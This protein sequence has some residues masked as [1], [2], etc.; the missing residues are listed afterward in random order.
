MS[1]ESLRDSILRAASAVTWV[2]GAAGSRR[3]SGTMGMMGAIRE[4]R[5][6]AAGVA[7]SSLPESRRR[8]RSGSTKHLKKNRGRIYEIG[9]QSGGGPAVVDLHAF[10]GLEAM[11]NISNRT[12]TAQGGGAAAGTQNR[13]ERMI[14]ACHRN[15][16]TKHSSFSKPR[17]T[18]L[19]TAP[20][21]RKTP[22][23][24][25]HSDFILRDGPETRASIG[26][27]EKQQQSG[28]RKTLR[29]RIRRPVS[30]ACRQP[31]SDASPRRSG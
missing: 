7:A 26:F 5:P 14:D 3:W 6:E 23:P 13:R 10:V 22:A 17:K 30:A 1:G 11:S 12:P 24:L 21:Y 4:D 19:K 15:H 20:L 28:E 29:P 18:F 9:R 16:C 2:L 27:E 25:R 8:A 31:P